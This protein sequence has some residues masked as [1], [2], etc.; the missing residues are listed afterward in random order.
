MESRGLLCAL[1]IGFG[2]MLSTTITNDYKIAISGFLK[3]Y[4]FDTV[5]RAFRVKKQPKL[6]LLEESVPFLAQG[7]FC[8]GQ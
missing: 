6:R 5:A 1:K 3:I 7:I 8:L 2:K 4:A